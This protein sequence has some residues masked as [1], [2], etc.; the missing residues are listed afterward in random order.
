MR[1]YKW[2]ISCVLYVKYLYSFAYTGVWV[3]L[4]KRNTIFPVPTFLLLFD[5]HFSFFCRN[6]VTGVICIAFQLCKIA[7]NRTDYAGQLLLSIYP[8]SFVLDF[9]NSILRLR[10]LVDSLKNPAFALG[11]RG[12]LLYRLFSTVFLSQVLNEHTDGSNVPLRQ[13]GYVYR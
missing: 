10:A 7:I 13:S 8:L 1:I 6:V 2:G 11:K 4:P 9:S 5:F 12:I 3:Y